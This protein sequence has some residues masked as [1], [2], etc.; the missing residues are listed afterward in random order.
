[1]SSFYPENKMQARAKNNFAV[2]DLLLISVGSLSDRKGHHRVIDAMPKLIQQFPT[3]KLLI[4]GGPTSFEDLTDALSNR[5]NELGLGE[6]VQ[7]CGQANAEQLRWFFSASDLFVLATAHEGRANVMNEAL[8]CGLPIVTTKVG[9]NAE[10]VD[11][12]A[13]GRVVD[14]WNE[15]QFVVACA[16]YLRDPKASEPRLAYAKGLTW[17]NSVRQI[18]DRFKQLIV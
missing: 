1:L 8:A 5:I 4:V 15:D 2:D 18:V 10:I 16:E 17:T 7:M 9:G 6:H 14:F 3:A 13:K 11:S 12:P